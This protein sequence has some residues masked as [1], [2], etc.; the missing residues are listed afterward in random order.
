MNKN[1]LLVFLFSFKKQSIAKKNRSNIFENKC[2]VGIIIHIDFS[3]AY[4]IISVRGW[5][6]V[7][8]LGAWTP[9]I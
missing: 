8:S 4:Y 2:E 1:V 9:N 3:Q 5:Y 7:Y 6:K